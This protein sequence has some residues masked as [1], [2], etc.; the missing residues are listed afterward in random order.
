[1]RRLVVAVALSS[2]PLA[3]SADRITRMAQPDLCAYTARLQVIAAH[4]YKT[5]KARQDVKIYWHGDET[6]NEIDFVNR[7]ID[8]GYRMIE[9]EYESGRKDTPLEILGDRVFEA[10]MTAKSL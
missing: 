8:E 5:G 10:C 9:R 1:M 6:E 3:S 4:Y 2:F 7:T